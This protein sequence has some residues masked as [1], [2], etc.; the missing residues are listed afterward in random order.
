MQRRDCIPPVQRA[1]GSLLHRKTGAKYNREPPWLMSRPNKAKNRPLN[2]ARCNVGA[3]SS[4]VCAQ[5]TGETGSPF[6][7]KFAV[8]APGGPVHPRFAMLA[9]SVR[10]ERDRFGLAVETGW[11]RGLLLWITK[12]WVDHGLLRFQGELPSVLQSSMHGNRE[13]LV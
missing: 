3:P 5:P 11:N 6:S 10:R 8:I 12:S 9:A 1:P 4:W 13:T 7:W 2:N